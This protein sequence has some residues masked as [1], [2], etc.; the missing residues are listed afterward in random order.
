MSPRVRRNMQC[1]AQIYEVAVQYCRNVIASIKRSPSLRSLIC[2]QSF[3]F[4]VHEMSIVYALALRAMSAV[5]SS[6]LDSAV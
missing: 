1:P 2:P 4:A 6:V 5:L 3:A